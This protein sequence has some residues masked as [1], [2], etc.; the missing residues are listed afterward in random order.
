MPYEELKPEDIKGIK[1]AIETGGVPAKQ[2][3]VFD[4]ALKPGGKVPVLIEPESLHF[5]VAGGAP[6]CAFSFNYYRIP[7]YNKT[8]ILTKKIT[9]AI[10]TRAGK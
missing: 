6:G 10:Q 8:A 9:G 5:F 7:P 3:P 1:E 4:A 2:K